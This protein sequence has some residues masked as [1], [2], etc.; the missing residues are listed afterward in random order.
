MLAAAV[1]LAVC[2]STQPWPFA[3]QHPANH[4][5]CVAT[6]LEP[7][8]YEGRRKEGKVDSGQ[9]SGMIV[10]RTARVTTIVLSHRAPCIILAT[11]TLL[12]YVPSTRRRL[13]SSIPGR[14]HHPLV[15]LPPFSSY[16]RPSS[17]IAQWQ[18]T[19]YFD[20]L[21]CTTRLFPRRSPATPGRARILFSP[22]SRLS[23]VASPITIIPTY[24]LLGNF[25][26]RLEDEY[27]SNRAPARA[28]DVS[29]ANSDTHFRQDSMRSDLPH[30]LPI[31]CSIRIHFTLLTVGAS[32]L[33]VLVSPA[34]FNWFEL[35][36]LLIL[37][38]VS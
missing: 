4:T 29:A 9:S 38:L 23:P 18:A 17:S 31:A 14:G 10:S 26:T 30:L 16:P 15:S 36:P 37:L 28:I 35:A 11:T 20:P 6:Q 27:A 24:F 25:S 8:L 21:L 1:R 22:C 34:T 19:T 13:P 12:K 33:L 32:F 7:R 2:L 3:R 5:M